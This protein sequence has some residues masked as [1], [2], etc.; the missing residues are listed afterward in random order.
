MLSTTG[1][2]SCPVENNIDC[3]YG[4]FLDFSVLEPKFSKSL[5]MLCLQVCDIFT[6][7]LQNMLMMQQYSSIFLSVLS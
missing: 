1:D 7:G 5:F 4:F 3:C 2:F 6:H